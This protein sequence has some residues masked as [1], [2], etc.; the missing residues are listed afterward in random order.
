ME[1]LNKRTYKIKSF[2]IYQYKKKYMRNAD[3]KRILI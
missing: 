1:H 2:H 3:E